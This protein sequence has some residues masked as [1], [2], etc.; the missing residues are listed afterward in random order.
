M[1]HSTKNIKNAYLGAGF[2]LIA[3]LLFAIINTLIQSVTMQL[4]ESSSTV[5]FWQYTVALIFSVPWV[6]SRIRST[7]ATSQL[8]LQIARVVLAAAGVQLWVL[9]LAVV[10]IWQ[11]IA[12]IM[13]S[14]FFVTLGAGVLL[15]EPV[16]A[17]RWLAVGAGFSGGMIILAP[18]SNTFSLSALYPVCAAMLWALSSLLTKYLVRSERP[19]TLTIYLLILLTPINAVLAIGSGFALHTSAAVG[20]VVIAGVLTALAQYGLAK[21]YSVADAAYLQPFDHVKL[22]FNVTLGWLAFGFMPDG[23]MWFGAAVI[24]CASFILLNS[25]AKI[26]KTRMTST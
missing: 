18:W 15:K 1:T 20:F 23:N 9:G 8:F 16:S 24:I 14:P 25:E 11:A 3:G 13:T 26:P 5:V 4:G 12:L 17:Q 2:M 10:P 7:L 6:S 21:A 22:I 19:E